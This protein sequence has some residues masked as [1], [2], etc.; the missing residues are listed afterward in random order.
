MKLCI[1]YLFKSLEPLTKWGPSIKYCLTVLMAIAM[2]FIV[3]ITAEENRLRLLSHQSTQ[4]KRESKELIKNYP[5]LKSL[6]F[7]NI[8]KN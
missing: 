2:S 8:Q 1:S 7:L 5:F 4:M 6:K 3:I